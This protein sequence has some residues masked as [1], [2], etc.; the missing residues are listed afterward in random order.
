MGLL[1]CELELFVMTDAEMQR[2]CNLVHKGAKLYV[3]RDHA[4]RQKLKIIHGPFGLLTQRFRCTIE[5]FQVLK[6]RLSNEL[7]PTTRVH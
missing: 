4:G 2:V 5:D 1:V 3:G 7:V 6:Q